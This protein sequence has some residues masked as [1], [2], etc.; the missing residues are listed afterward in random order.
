[1]PTDPLDPDRIRENLRTKRI[2]SKI[3]VYNS[4][5]STNNIA[6]EYGKNEEN[7]GLVVFAEEQTTGRGRVGTKWHSNRGDSILCSI[8]L[9]KCDLNVELLS[10]ACAVAVAEAVGGT[11]QSEAKI[12]WPND[13][14][15]KGKKVAGILLESKPSRKGISYIIGVGINCHQRPDSFPSELRSSATSIDMEDHTSCDRISVA[16]RLLSSTEHWLGVAGKNRTAVAEQWQRLSLQLGHRITLSYNGK[17]YTGNCVG[18]D[19]LKGLIVQ[20]E[21][22]GVTFFDAMHT[23]VLKAT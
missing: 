16:K 13:I 18:I 14:V 2:G 8:V 21:T 17:M 9:T 10:L 15:L 11:V 7:D 23:T 22:G 5:S 1:M 12:K 20:L 6:A 4:T 3:L 19:P